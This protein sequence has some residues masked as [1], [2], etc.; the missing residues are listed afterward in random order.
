MLLLHVAT[1]L[2]IWYVTPCLYM[3]NIYICMCVCFIVFLDSCLF[4]HVLLHH[5]R[6]YNRYYWIYSFWGPK[7]GG[8]FDMRGMGFCLKKYNW[9]YIPRKNLFGYI[10]YCIL[11]YRI[12]SHRNQIKT[13]LRITL[14][15]PFKS[16]SHNMKIQL[17]CHKQF[18]V[19]NSHTVLKSPLNHH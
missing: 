14:K 1:Y 17:K 19:F 12:K 16:H 15:Y 4:Y 18:V 10:P 3:Y 6:W 7:N 9:P 2:N 5:L 13:P 11:L 8:V